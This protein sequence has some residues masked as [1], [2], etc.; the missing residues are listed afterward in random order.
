MA[1]KHGLI[2][3]DDDGSVYFLRPEILEAAKVPPALHSHVHGGTETGN[4]K[5]KVLGTLDPDSEK[6]A[7]TGEAKG[8]KVTLPSTLMCPW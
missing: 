7:G 5:A 6:L 3:Q 1:H 2:G 8:M 4:P